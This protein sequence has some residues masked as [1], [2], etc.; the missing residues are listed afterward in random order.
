MF[1]ELEPMQLG[2]DGKLGPVKEACITAAQ[3]VFFTRMKTDTHPVLVQMIHLGELVPHWYYRS[4][5]WIDQPY[6]SPAM[7]LQP[8]RGPANLANPGLYGPG[9]FIIDEKYTIL[10]KK[11]FGIE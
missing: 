7:F 3:R 4:D 11:I 10:T 9:K 6:Y 8:Y 1:Y 5:E 2:D